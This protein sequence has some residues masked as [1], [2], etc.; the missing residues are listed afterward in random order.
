VA[1]GLDLS[2]QFFTGRHVRLFEEPDHFGC[3]LDFTGEP[4]HAAEHVVQFRD[5]PHRGLG[6]FGNG[7]EIRLGAGFGEFG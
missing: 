3:V 6:A 2:G 4:V 5:T 1:H 7:P